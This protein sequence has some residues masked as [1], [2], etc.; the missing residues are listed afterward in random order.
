MPL[1]KNPTEDRQQ[2]SRPPRKRKTLDINSEAYSTV[3]V[4]HDLYRHALNQKGLSQKALVELTHDILEL[5]KSIGTLQALLDEKIASRDAANKVLQ[6]AYSDIQRAT[7]GA[8]GQELDIITEGSTVT[9][10]TIETL[11]GDD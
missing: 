10:E 6:A 5:E 11:R 3:E 7:G 9:L 2:S 8:W 4:D 1:P